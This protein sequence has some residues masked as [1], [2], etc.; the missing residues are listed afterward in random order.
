MRLILPLLLILLFSACS[1]HTKT[2][3]IS[4]KTSPGIKNEGSVY[5]LL[6]YSV[7]FRP[8]GLATFPDGGTRVFATGGI[9]LMSYQEKEN[10]L[11]TIQKLRIKGAIPFIEY[12]ELSLE[13]KLLTIRMQYYPANSPTMADAYYRF[14]P[15]T[16]TILE[17][18]V[19]NF[20][21]ESDPGRIVP[22]HKTIKY[23]D[24][25]FD[26]GAI[27]LPDPIE[28]VDTDDAALKEMI[29]QPD[30]NGR[31]KKVVLGYIVKQEKRRILEALRH[32]EAVDTE[33]QKMIDDVLAQ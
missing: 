30:V 29:R 4:I 1:T 19:K 31:F 23:F 28:L 20:V 12:S 32:D 5:F 24:P 15:G 26:Y 11:Q 14:T 22:S 27:G 17:A 13:E 16:G 2:P 3:S 18:D 10:R 9:Y 8:T 25:V 21:P 6:K 7:Y 33:I